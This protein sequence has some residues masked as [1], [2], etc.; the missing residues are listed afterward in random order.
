MA[1]VNEMPGVGRDSCV[2]LMWWQ[3]WRA[4]LWLFHCPALKE[5]AQK[6]FSL[7]LMGPLT[8]KFLPRGEM[9]PHP[10]HPTASLHPSTVIY[11]KTGTMAPG[12]LQFFLCFRSLTGLIAR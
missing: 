1:L 9:S 4:R 10:Q 8:C 6:N 11:L 2:S 12:L 3:T 7:V 5:F